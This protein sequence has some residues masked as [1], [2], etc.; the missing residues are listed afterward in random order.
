MFV[1]VLGLRQAVAKDEW[2]RAD[3]PQFKAYVQE[4]AADRLIR[5]IYGDHHDLIVR[6]LHALRAEVASVEGHQLLGEI[7]QLIRDKGVLP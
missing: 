7:E 2:D 5:E 4:R 6:L 1:G 3:D